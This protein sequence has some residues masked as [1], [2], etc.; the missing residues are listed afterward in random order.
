MKNNE[1]FKC[2]GHGSV[3]T[4]SLGRDYFLYHAYRVTDSVY[5]GR[6]GML[7]PITWGEDGWPAINSRK[8]PGGLVLAKPAAF[9]Y[10][11]TSAAPVMGWQWPNGRKPG[12]SLADG[13]LTL[14]P[15]ADR[16]MDVIGGALARSSPSGSY[17]AVA[18]VDTSGVTAG[19]RA[20][21]VALTAGGVTGASARFDSLRITPE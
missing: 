17:T 1:A 19:A 12:M 10:D 8:G 7:D 18:I 6:Q 16:A 5:A 21:R 9:F 14:T 11:F 20:V 4:D 13:M 15:S 2:P 3:V